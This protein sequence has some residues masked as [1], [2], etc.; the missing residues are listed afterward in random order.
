MLRC[1]FLLSF[2]PFLLKLCSAVCRNMK[3]NTNQLAPVPLR[4]DTTFPK[5]KAIDPKNVQ[6]YGRA[7][8]WQFYDRNVITEE[9]TCKKCKKTT[10][11]QKASNLEKHLRNKHP[12]LFTKLAKAHM[13][14]KNAERTP[15]PA[16]IQ[17]TVV[18][19]F[20]HG[21]KYSPNHVKQQQLERL[22]A[23]AC[24]ESSIPYRVADKRWMGQLLTTLNKQFTVPHRRKLRS[25]VEDEAQVVRVRVKSALE[26]VEKVR[27]ILF[28]FAI[29][30]CRC[31]YLWIYGQ[32]VE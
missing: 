4:L 27:H 10:T 18:E 31:T 15:A 23:L 21:A 16:L 24:A 30:F 9:N 26:K 12:E 1:E 2:C 6:P 5:G 32:N 28:F 25:L 8:V 14:L 11:D 22:F 3:S 17:R 29:F 19:A 7:R 13:P 20:T